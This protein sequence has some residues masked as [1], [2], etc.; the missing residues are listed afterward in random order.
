MY[1]YF[2]TNSPI[3]R[4]MWIQYLLPND[5]LFWHITIHKTD[6]LIIKNAFDMVISLMSCM[7]LCPNLF[8]I[9]GQLT[10]M[11]SPNY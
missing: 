5:L 4:Q 1:L 6:V 7:T 11:L 2:C 8:L 3:L 9:N 10:S